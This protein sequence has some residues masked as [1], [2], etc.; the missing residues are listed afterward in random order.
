MVLRKRAKRGCQAQANRTVSRDLNSAGMRYD[1]AGIPS[2][3][4]LQMAFVTKMPSVFL[5]ST[6][7][8]EFFSDDPMLTRL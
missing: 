3:V 4:P 1:G 5:A 8:M 6:L 2:A 7:S